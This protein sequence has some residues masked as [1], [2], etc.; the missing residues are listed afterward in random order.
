MRAAFDGIVDGRHRCRP[1]TVKPGW[2]AFWTL[3]SSICHLGRLYLVRPLFGPPSNSLK[4]CDDSLCE[5]GDVELVPVEAARQAQRQQGLGVEEHPA[6]LLSAGDVADCDRVTTHALECSPRWTAADHGMTPGLFG[7]GT[8]LELKRSLMQSPYSGCPPK[9]FAVAKSGCGFLL[10]PSPWGKQFSEGDSNGNR[11]QSH[12]RCG[13]RSGKALTTAAPI[14]S[15]KAATR[16]IIQIRGGAFGCG[17][18]ADRLGLS[19]SGASA[20]PS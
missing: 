16:S 6:A 13:F 10:S 18:L 4:F 20:F 17:V 7:R 3:Q 15:F 8:V 1:A 9:T 2:L 12:N 19:W 11:H 5:A 14:S